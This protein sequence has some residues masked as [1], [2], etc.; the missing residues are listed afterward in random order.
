[1]NAIVIVTGTVN[2]LVIIVFIK[3]HIVLIRFL[4]DNK[5]SHKPVAQVRQSPTNVFLAS[6]ASADLLLILVCLPLKVN[7]LVIMMM[8]FIIMIKKL[9]VIMIMLIIMM[10]IVMTFMM[11]ISSS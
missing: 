8:M 6:L 10:T 5:K 7:M 2:I 1:M 9:I 4:I 3:C 11:M